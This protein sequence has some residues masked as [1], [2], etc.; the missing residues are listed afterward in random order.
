MELK[1]YVVRA[2]SGKERKA[3]ECL[4]SEIA[5]N[6]MSDLV[7]QILIPL[8]K[9]LQLKNGKK[10]ILTPFRCASP[11]RLALNSSRSLI[12]ISLNCATCGTAFQLRC[13]LIAVSLCNLLRGTS[14]ISP[15]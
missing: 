3:K 8:E 13:I 7:S 4:E 15:N 11:L 1:W 12:S 9:V 5:Y 14:S 6:G 2:I 10:V